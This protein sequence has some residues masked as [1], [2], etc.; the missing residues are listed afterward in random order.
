MAFLNNSGDIILDAVLTDEGRRRLAL[1]DGTFKIA[2]FALGDDEIDYSQWDSTNTSG[3]AYYDLN[4]LQTPVLE[5]F[6][7]NASSMKSKLVTYASTN[8]LYLPVMRLNTREGGT[9]QGFDTSSIG[10]YVAMIYPEKIT[11]ANDGGTYGY[12]SRNNQ[13]FAAGNFNATAVGPRGARCITVAQGLD[14]TNIPFTTT[15]PNDLKETKYLIEM[16]DR[17]GKICDQSSNALK[18]AF[19]DDDSIATY[20]VSQQ[21]PNIWT[22][23]TAPGQ[24]DKSLTTAPGIIAGPYNTKQLTFSMIASDNLTLSNY[25]FSQFGNTNDRTDTAYTLVYSIDTSI[26]VV[27]QTT[28][29]RITIPV[30]IVKVVTQQTKGYKNGDNI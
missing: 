3:S 24:L 23:V 19:V 20:A 2:K 27:G 8:L 16:D 12:T 10:T 29:Y 7:N 18:P 15:I 1:G 6:T 28:G 21:T 14:T 25:Y 17:L 26:A 11:S 9:V 5:A 13:T 22:D 4:I 30:R